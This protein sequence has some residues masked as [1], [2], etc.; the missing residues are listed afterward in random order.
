MKKKLST[1]VFILLIILMA[2]NAFSQSMGRTYKTALGVKFYPA[3][4][5]I[6]HFTSNKVALEGWAISGTM[7]SG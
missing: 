7:V 2:V 3:S 4:I 5:S 1:I 6:K